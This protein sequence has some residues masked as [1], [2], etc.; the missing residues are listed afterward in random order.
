[1]HEYVHVRMDGDGDGERQVGVPV[2]VGGYPLTTHL[3]GG[4]EG[5]QP[6][7]LQLVQEVLLCGD[8]SR[9][10]LDLQDGRGGGTGDT[11]VPVVRRSLF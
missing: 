7:V 4:G 8:T 3:S 5:Q 10:A 2:V 6:Q 1:M 11:A 9:R